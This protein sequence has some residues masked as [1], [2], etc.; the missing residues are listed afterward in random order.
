ME[1]KV[2]KKSLGVGDKQTTVYEVKQYVDMVDID[3]KKVKVCMGQTQTLTE[4]QYI[5]E[6]AKRQL[7][8]D[9]LTLA[10]IDAD[11]VK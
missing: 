1:L 11:K 7:E 8:I 6:L 3:G 10:K 2:T 5:K 9:T 4:E